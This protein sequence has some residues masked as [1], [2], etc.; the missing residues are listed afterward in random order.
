[1]AID[2][3]QC[4]LIFCYLQE[5]TVPEEEIQAGYLNLYMPLKFV[6]KF[7]KCIFF[8]GDILR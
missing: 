5:K 2:L 3:L 1:M 6:E 4:E 7:K 8:S